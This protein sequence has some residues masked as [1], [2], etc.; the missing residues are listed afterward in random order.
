MAPHFRWRRSGCR[1]WSGGGIGLATGRR[2]GREGYAV[3]GVP[4]DRDQ[5]GAAAQGCWYLVNAAGVIVLK[6]M[7]GVDTVEDLRTLYS[8]N[9]EAVWGLTSRIGRSMPN[10]GAIV[11]LS[12]SSATLATTT[13]AASYASSKAVVL[14]ITRSFAYAFANQ[15]VRVN[16]ICSGVIDTP[17]QDTFVERVASLRGV[18]VEE[19]GRLRNATVPLGRAASADECAG[20][21]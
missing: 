17:M 11:N 21:I 10:G 1:R 2:L 14:S 8:V 12:S 15:G 6:P 18:S 3:L 5:L 16:A 7:M 20:A 9:V 13:E 19:L 4:A